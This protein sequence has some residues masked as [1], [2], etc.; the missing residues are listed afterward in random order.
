MPG[1]NL[2]ISSANLR[3]SGANMRVFAANMRT[4]AARHPQVAGMMSDV[5]GTGGRVRIQETPSGHPTALLDEVHLHGLRNPLEDAVR[6]A[7]REVDPACTAIIILGFGLGY[8]AEAARRLFPRLPVLVVEPDAGVFAAAL[9]SRDLLHLLSDPSVYLH[10]DPHP[11][12]LPHLLDALP[13]ARPCFLRLRPAI[14][15]NPMAY[16]AAEETVQSWRLRRD[17]NVNTLARFGRLWVRN[18]CRNLDAFLK[19][20]GVADLAGIFRDM[21][22][23]IVAGGPSL[24][25]LL[26]HLP[27]LQ[28]RM[29]IVAV[30]T[31][32][33]ACR[34]FAVEPDFTVVVDP[35]YWASRYLDWT[36]SDRGVLVAE[37]S[38]CPRVFRREDAQFF[39]CSS[40]FPLGEILEGAVGEKGKLGAG[41]SVATSAWDLARML[42]ARPLY[43]AGL[44][45]GFPGMRTHC[46]GVFAEEVWISAADRLAPVEGSSFRS[47]HD[48]GLFPA[49]SAAGGVTPT[50]RRMLL[51]KWWFENQMK[52]QP[53]FACFTLSPDGIAVEGIP[54]ARLEQAFTLPLIRHEIDR[55]MTRVKEIH[56]GQT[57]G[58]DSRERLRASIARVEEELGALQVL[59]RRGETLSRELGVILER[60]AGARESLDALDD[61]DKG[62]LSLSSRTIAGFLV[63]SILHRIEGEGDSTA[64]REAVLARSAALYEGIAESAGWQQELLRRARE[65]IFP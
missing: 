36:G 20:P 2:R 31:P 56:R 48:I 26:P 18:L 24:D 63:Q 33:S 60:R 35:Q 40:L 65:A 52:M 38:A 54:L 15:A 9:S 53:D 62:I 8:T 64:D 37:P 46:R 23:L 13:M 6:Q 39:L 49:R 47:I 34:A 12:G 55:R 50:D 32:V 25:A 17:I 30:N 7:E 45:L 41:G 28:K 59:C 3:I 14:R 27:E 29:L 61:V 21:P 19:C 57:P 43:V 1:A 58:V 16:R 22:G 11:E 44:D 4:L 42:G 10:V 51:Y 5:G